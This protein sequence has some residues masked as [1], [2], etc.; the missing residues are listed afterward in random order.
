[1]S[2]VWDRSSVFWMLIMNFSQPNF[3]ECR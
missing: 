2:N 3:E 1:M